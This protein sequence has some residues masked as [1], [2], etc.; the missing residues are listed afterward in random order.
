MCLLWKFRGTI[1]GEAL[2]LFLLFHHGGGSMEYYEE[3]YERDDYD[4]TGYGEGNLER[5]VYVTIAVLAIASA[6]V[7]YIS[8]L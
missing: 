1:E 2:C 3:G 6:A 4:F 5:V 7:V 8:F